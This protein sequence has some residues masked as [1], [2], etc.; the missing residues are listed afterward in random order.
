ML[1]SPVSLV[2]VLRLCY[3]YGYIYIYVKEIWVMQGAVCI[4]SV[5]FASEEDFHK[6]LSRRLRIAS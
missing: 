5:R 1:V 2:T 3:N 4:E 6:D